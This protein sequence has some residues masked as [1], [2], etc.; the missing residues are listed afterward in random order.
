MLIRVLLLW[1]SALAPA[2]AKL[3]PLPDMGAPSDRIL[4]PLEEERLGQAFFRN[5]H[6]HVRVSDDP[7][8]QDYIASLGGRL[9]GH[10]D[11]ANRP[12]HFF[13][14]ME[15]EINA[16]AGPAGY[17]GVHS[18][19]ILATRSESELASVLAHEIA[20][21]TQNHLKRAFASAKRLSIPLA[22]AML[23]AI[24]VGTQSPEAAQAAIIA[25]QAGGLQQQI[26][27]TRAHEQEADRI[28]LQILADSGFDPR[29]MPAFFERLQQSTRLSGR[30]NVPEFLR[31]HPMTSSRIADTRARAADYPYRQY[32]D[33]L[34]YLLVKAK[35]EVL[36]S[37]EPARLLPLFRQRLRHGTPMQKAAARYGLALVH[38]SLHRLEESRKL[39]RQLLR[40][41]PDQPQ[42]VD[43]LARVELAQG[44]T[45]SALQRYRLAL[46]HFPAS[47]MLQLAYSQ[48]LLHS[49]RFGEARRRLLRLVAR[50][51][52][53]PSLYKHLSQAYAGMGETA[54]AQRYLAEYHYATGDL[55]QA[56]RYARLALKMARGDRILTAIARERLRFFQQEE[57]ARKR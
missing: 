37:R 54:E 49:G 26:N 7:M 29:S 13:V 18:G 27:F 25:I 9:T 6:R 11:M 53:P 10:S 3:P 28:G 2:A 56:I 33:S 51:N 4:S 17:I 40:R 1:L 22:A 36:S 46:K 30:R 44:D 21:V 45:E 43:A 31:T 20:H 34:A 55:E 41:F 8:I 50:G 38:R 14:V 24:L 39:L 47:T 57:K 35:L 15:P 52:V 16:F 42:F 48:A 32:T 5:L 23:A 19:L 12:F